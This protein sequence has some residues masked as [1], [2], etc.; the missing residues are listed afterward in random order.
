MRDYDSIYLEGGWRK[1]S[2]GG[3]IP[4][5]S[6]MT[7]E[8]FASAPLAA[9]ADVDA[10]VAAARRALR[11]SEWGA[12]SPEER[13]AFM[14]RLA[15]EMD[16]NLEDRAALTTSQNGMPIGLSY[17]VEGHATTQILR[18][19]V[20]LARSTPLEELRP[21]GDG[22]GSTVVRREPVGVVA[23]IVPWNFPQVLTIN[24]VAPALAAGCTLVLKPSPETTLD[25]LELAA[26]ADRAGLPAGVLNVVTGGVEI[27]R[28]LVA[29]PGVNKVAF[30]GSS[31]AGREIGETAGRLLRPATLELGGKSAAIVLDDADLATTVEGLASAAL[32]H[33]GQACYLCTRIL[34]PRRRHDE[35]LH[36]VAGLASSM[37]IGDPFDMAVHLGPL[38][39]ERQRQRVE[40]YIEAGKASGATLA[41]GGG[42]PEMDKGW[43]VQ[44]TVFG[45]VSNDAKI[46]REEIFGPVLA[47]MPY[48]DLDEAVSI[49]NDSEFGLGG[50]V[51]TSDPEKGMDVARRIESGTVGVNF[52]MLD[53]GAPFGGVKGSGLGRELGPEGLQAY[54]QLKSIYRAN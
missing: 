17:A 9:L 11:S 41:A 43:Y 27:G 23:A 52:Y 38:V 48:D 44:P 53:P 39:S 37:N 50:T 2:S 29:H 54:F 51:W 32:M 22:L 28:Y 40:S 47:V 15:D 21:R 7:E 45:N 42:R 49:A 24:K 20:E 30:T 35:V 19:Y 6:P 8:Q 34:A 33:S 13:A 36:A 1:P 31:A 18:Y 14:E 26:A 10:A 12:I 16:K 3:T 25:A 46:A 4:V 5:I